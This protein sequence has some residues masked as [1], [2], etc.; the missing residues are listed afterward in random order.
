M[1][2]RGDGGI[3]WTVG[4]VAQ[5]AYSS[6]YL[7][8]R[9]HGRPSQLVGRRVQ[10]APLPKLSALCKIK[11]YSAHKLGLLLRATSLLWRDKQTPPRQRAS[12]AERSGQPLGGRNRELAKTRR[13]GLSSEQARRAKDHESGL[14]V[15]GY[16]CPL[17]FKSALRLANSGLI[18]RES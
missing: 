14:Q 10:P 13:S 15:R 8:D 1:V 11:G 17:A 12:R 16:L 18:A 5:L 2:I 6:G 4:S 7:Y 3:V 9:A